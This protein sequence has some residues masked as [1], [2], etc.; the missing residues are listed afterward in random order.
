M[1]QSPDELRLTE[2]EVRHRRELVGLG[3]ADAQR[4]RRLGEKLRPRLEELVRLFFQY[5]NGREEARALLGQRELYERAEAMKRRHLVAMFSGEYGLDY[6]RQRVA[7]GR[8][9]SKAELPMRVFLGAYHRVLQA[10]GETLTEPGELSSL[11]KVACFDVSLSVD[12]LVHS[13]EQ[14]ILQ[15]QESIRQASVPVLKLRDRLLLVPVIG[16]IDSRRARL[17]TE[18]MLQAA[19]AARARVVVMD[20]TGV[21][22]IDTR[23]AHHVL[24]A[25]HAARLMG[26]KVL[27]SGLHAEVTQ[28]LSVLGVDVSRL[29]LIEDLERGIA[30]AER[31]LAPAPEQGERP[32][33]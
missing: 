2:E 32:V 31:H 24:Q 20:V 16:I 8:L 11:E 10:I 19:R 27:V 13:R 1:E 7:L 33:H 12:A 21:A 6:A 18:H 26:V 17:L 14:V 25:V 30:E 23:V 15:Q 4:L 3:D 22:N 29:E 28:A 9:Y 5:L